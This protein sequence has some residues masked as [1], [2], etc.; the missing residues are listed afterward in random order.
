[1]PFIAIAIALAGAPTQSGRSQLYDADLSDASAQ[2]Q[3]MIVEASRLTPTQRQN[4]GEFLLRLLGLSKRLH[5]IEENASAAEADLI[6][7]G[8]APSNELE[9]ATAISNQLDTAQDMLVRYID[10]G[11]RNFWDAAVASAQ[12]ARG[13]MADQ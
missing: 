3:S 11:D 8:N 5:R 2:L 6:R 7:R 10:T 9:Y 13:L 12:I 1:M 4:A